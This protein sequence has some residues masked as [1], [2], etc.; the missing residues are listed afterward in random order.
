MTP[1]EPLIQRHC[2]LK[3]QTDRLVDGEKTRMGFAKCESVAGD[4]TTDT[5]L[6][7]NKSVPAVIRIAVSN[8]ATVVAARC[9]RRGR[10]PRIARRSQTAATAQK[11]TANGKPFPQLHS[12]GQGCPGQG[13]QPIAWFQLLVLPLTILVMVGAR[14]HDRTAPGRRWCPLTP[15]HHPR[16]AHPAGRLPRPTAHCPGRC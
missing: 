6:H 7:S 1:D 12:D 16:Q 10:N 2:R 11:E 5:A 9:E 14:R 3:A 15:A 8:C 4:D 13:L